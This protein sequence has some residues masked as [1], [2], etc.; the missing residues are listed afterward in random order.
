M[1]KINIKIRN[2]KKE[3]IPSV[4][5]IKI[6]GW[7]TAYK[8]II[9]EKYL[10]NLSNEY[11]V[12]VKKNVIEGNKMVFFFFIGGIFTLPCAIFNILDNYIYKNIESRPLGIILALGGQIFLTILL[13]QIA[14]IVYKKNNK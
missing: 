13:Y 12:M 8:E 4:V 11:E 3:D 5:D 6:K 9:D 2:V 14:N 7:Q 10:V 1:I